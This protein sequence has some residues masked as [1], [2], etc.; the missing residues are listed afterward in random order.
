MHRAEPHDREAVG[1]CLAQVWPSTPE[2]SKLAAMGYGDDHARALAILGEL[3]PLLDQ[4]DPTG[5]VG[6]QSRV[7][8]AALS[9]LASWAEGPHQAEVCR[10]SA[11]LS[12]LTK[13][14]DQVIDAMPF[15]GG[16]ALRDEAARAALRAKTAAFLAPSLR[17]IRTGEVTAGD[18]SWCVLAAA[19]GRGMESLGGPRKA[20]LLGFIEEGWA[21]QAE[22]V[23]LFSRHPSQAP[24]A[25]VERV[26]TRISA[27]WLL[28]VAAC[29]ELAPDSA[30]LSDAEVADFF[31][32]GAPI[33]RIDALNDLEKDLADG[34]VASLPGRLLWQAQGDA[35]LQDWRR[36]DWVAIRG[37]VQRFGVEARCVLSVP[38]GTLPLRRGLPE[39]LAWVYAHL[40]GRNRAKAGE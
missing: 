14:E 32:W 36:Q 4:A 11:M 10:L 7:L 22:A 13:I 15:H 26:T 35:F 39:R 5:L 27:L 3:Q 2:A 1:L 9:G 19:L 12:L 37:N 33:Q 21:V 30:P 31:A 17:A 16:P 25:E 28:M 18:H 23:E 24:L 29:G 34:L 40:A 6:P 38:E 8:C 20:R